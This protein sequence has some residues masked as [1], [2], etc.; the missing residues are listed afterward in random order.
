MT[1]QLGKTVIDPPLALAPMV[2][3]SHSALR[4]IIVRLG[5]VGLLFTEMLSAKRVNHENEKISPFLV[6]SEE[7]KPLF[8]Q[9]YATNNEDFAGVAAKL[10]ELNAQGVD[11]NLGCPAPNIRRLGAG[12]FLLDRPDAV[13]EVLRKLRKNIRLPLSVKIRIGQSADPAKLRDTC[14]MLESEGVDL[15]TVH[16]RLDSEKFCRLPRWELLGPVT[17]V[18]SVPV[19]ANGGIFSIDDARKCLERSGAAGLMIGRGAACAPWLFREIACQIYKKPINGKQ[20]SKKEIYFSF[21]DILEKRFAPERRL[22]R[23][24][25][26]T[27]Y[28]ASSYQFGHHLASMIQGSKTMIEARE[29]AYSFMENAS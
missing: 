19:F 7:E 10:E 1:L 25:Q 15:I 13:K 26:F 6:R 24:K 27:H 12:K 14:L 8:Y 17:S 2:G 5:G 23:L 9:L 20:I 29:R 21:I 4:S 16:A 18:L 22:G 11:L 28:Y 3:L